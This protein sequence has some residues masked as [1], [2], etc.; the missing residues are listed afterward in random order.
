MGARTREAVVLL[1][2]QITLSELA[3]RSGLEREWL[4]ELVQ[5]GLL[6]AH[7]GDEPHFDPRSVAVALRARRLRTTFELD[8][9][10][11]AL[12]LS[13]LAQ[14]EALEARLRQMECHLPR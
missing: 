7:G 6:P 9:D 10:A 3:E 13:L 1:E 11:L 14:I 5:T 8:D 2:A 12:A 4:M